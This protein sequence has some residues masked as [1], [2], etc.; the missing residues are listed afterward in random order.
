MIGTE[1]VAASHQPHP[2]THQ[3]LRMGDRP[4][5]PGQATQPTAE[6][7]IQPLDIRSVDH[8]SRARGRQHPQDARARSMHHALRHARDV[9]LGRVFDDLGQLE[10]CRQHQAWA[11][12]PSGEHRMAEGGRKGAAEC[13]KPFETIRRWI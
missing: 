8:R 11:T 13:V 12:P 7:G 4:P 5:A 2:G 3:H 10:A 6:G 1:V 9:M